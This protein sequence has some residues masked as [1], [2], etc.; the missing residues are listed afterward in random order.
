MDSVDVIVDGVVFC[1]LLKEEPPQKQQKMTR[2]RRQA[3]GDDDRYEEFDKGQK[4]HAH[5]DSNEVHAAFFLGS[6][7][8]KISVPDRT[9]TGGLSKY[10]RGL[11]YEDL[12]GLFQATGRLLDK[13]DGLNEDPQEE[14]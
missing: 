4:L 6:Q 9:R 14:L 11:R 3:G 2:R 12:E 13:I 10:L 8:G 5:S 7:K 1:T